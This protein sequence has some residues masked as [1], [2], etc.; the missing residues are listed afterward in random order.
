MSRNFG[1]M[2]SFPDKTC[3][4]VR[5]TLTP[6]TWLITFFIIRMTILSMHVHAVSNPRVLNLTVVSWHV[7]S[8]SL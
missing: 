8:E 7:V 5:H 4:C 1:T 2:I 6:I 3:I